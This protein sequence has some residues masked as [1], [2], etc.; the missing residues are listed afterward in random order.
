MGY[1]KRV[2]NHTCC[3]FCGKEFDADTTTNGEHLFPAFACKQIFGTTDGSRRLQEKIKITVCKDCNSRYGDYLE[4]RLKKIITAIS[5]NDKT[6]M[7]KTEEAIV[8]LDYMTKTRVLLGFRAN[9]NFDQILGNYDF[10]TRWAA[11]DRQ[12]IIAKGPI[13][14][15]I[16]IPKLKSK[17]D[18]ISTENIE[19]I[20]CFAVVINGIIL[21][22]FEN[23][24]VSESLGFPFSSAV[25]LN[26]GLVAR[27]DKTILEY[28]HVGSKQISSMWFDELLENTR[29]S[30]SIILAQ[31]REPWTTDDYTQKYV[32][33]ESKNG[34][35]YGV[36]Y[37]TPVK[38][39]WLCKKNTEKGSKG[40]N[41]YN[42]ESEMTLPDFELFL[43]KIFLLEYTSV[44]VQH[45]YRNS[46]YTLL[47]ISN[48]I[49]A[50]LF[51]KYDTET[52]ENILAFD[53]DEVELYKNALKMLISHNF[54]KKQII[55][56][57]YKFV[58]FINE[59]KS[60]QSKN[61]K[62]ALQRFIFN[63]AGEKLM[64]IFLHQ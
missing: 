42:I 32:L 4:S 54:T 52:V 46:P 62:I 27:P 1:K 8:L 16:Y 58:R 28:G 12:L 38:S 45:T 10:V 17:S 43:I 41:V 53:V 24:L 49:M 18:F 22:S 7:F 48:K 55:D 15:G 64:D 3:P 31:P 20:S 25:F 9:Q 63:I 47:E 34:Y 36:Y 11:Y 2:Q 60:N 56:R 57:L 44:S 5:N 59:Q 39:G 33:S 23:K 21:I 61:K 26:D 40:I 30:D 19:G 13:P 50:P 35:R 14:D 6:F 37:K 29:F 51:K